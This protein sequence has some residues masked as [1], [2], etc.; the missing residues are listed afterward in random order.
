M[1]GY[2]GC[3]GKMEIVENMRCS[4]INVLGFDFEAYQVACCDWMKRSTDV[5]MRSG[6]SGGATNQC[7]PSNNTAGCD[8]G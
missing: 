1:K 4:S 5:Y 3:S 8:N 2:D 6:H 7:I